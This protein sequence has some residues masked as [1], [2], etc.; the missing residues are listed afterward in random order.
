M[1]Y[2]SEFMQL[3]DEIRRLNQKVEQLTTV[4]NQIN[5][6]LQTIIANQQTMAINRGEPTQPAQPATE[7][8]P[9]Q[10]PADDYTYN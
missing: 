6:N 3:L 9:T 8:I 7:P 10:N 2:K 1:D 4:N 5:S